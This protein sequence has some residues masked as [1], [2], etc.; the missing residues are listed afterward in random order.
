[1]LW[2]GHHRAALGVGLNHYLMDQTLD[3]VDRARE[4]YRLDMLRRHGAG[5]APAGDRARRQFRE[6]PEP[7]EGWLLRKLRPIVA[8]SELANQL[9]VY[10]ARPPATADHVLSL[11]GVFSGTL[12]Y[13]V[14]QP[15]WAPS[16]PES[17]GF[18]LLVG[19]TVIGL[20]LPIAAM[21]YSVC[22]AC[23][24]AG[25]WRRLSLTKLP[26]LKPE[27]GKTPVGTPL[28]VIVVHRG[29]PCRDDCLR[30][31]DNFVGRLTIHLNLGSAPPTEER[32]PGTKKV[33]HR[34][35]KVGSGAKESLYVFDDLQDVLQDDADGRA[36]FNELENKEKAG[37][38]VLIWSRVVPDYRYSDRLG[39]ADRWFAR[40]RWDDADRRDRWSGLAGKFRVFVLDCS[41]VAGERFDKLVPATNASAV[42]T[43]MR[44]EAVVN[45]ELL[46]VG[47][48]VTCEVGREAREDGVTRL[49]KSAAACFNQLWAESTHDERLQLYALARG[50]VVNARRTAALSSL[51]NRGIVHEDPATGVVR[52]RSEAFREF[53]EH[54]IDHRELDTWRRQRS[55]VWRLIWPPVAIAGALGLAFL[56]MANPEMGATVLTT[57]L[58]LLPVAL[59]FLG[60]GRGASPAGTPST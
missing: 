30:C 18:L 6:E 48:D 15:L 58:A 51:V 17:G 5:A 9:M 50:G 44:E 45:P 11:R 14:G 53:V 2:F 40:G 47:A 22:A 31:C 32:V 28:R 12:G 52:F 37:S 7:K 34:A 43:V 41:V 8:H 26:A 4:D 36:L 19:L 49:R 1:M 23:T 42:R 55:G 21:A 13:D 59:P 38:H 20:A 16:E 24:V 33:I 39:R 54:D 10:R 29:E 60:G 56:A 3:S 46:L 27:N 25:R 35:A 57:L